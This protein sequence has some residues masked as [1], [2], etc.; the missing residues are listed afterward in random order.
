MIQ[1]LKFL[2]VDMIENLSDIFVRWNYRERVQGTLDRPEFE[3]RVTSRSENQ[4]AIV[5]HPLSLFITI[6]KS[7][8]R[9]EG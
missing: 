1:N 9:N 6:V 7:P 2:I 5:V 4:G 8:S 3:Y